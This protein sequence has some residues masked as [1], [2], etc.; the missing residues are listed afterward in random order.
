MS[1]TGVANQA[2]AKTVREKRCAACGDLFFCHAGGCW[3]D[4][5]DLTP[6]TRAQLLA[7]YSDC[8][9][10]TC[11]RREALSPPTKAA[12]APRRNQR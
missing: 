11:L 7:Q 6:E 8:L 1:T 2:P 3:C 12:G 4:E 9:C 10:P 5:I